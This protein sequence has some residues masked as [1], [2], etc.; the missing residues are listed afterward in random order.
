MHNQGQCL[1]SV[2]ISLV[3][4]MACPLQRL[5]N[6]STPIPEDVSETLNAWDKMYPGSYSKNRLHPRSNCSVLSL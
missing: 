5:F 2:N 1:V 4:T 6:I 3:N